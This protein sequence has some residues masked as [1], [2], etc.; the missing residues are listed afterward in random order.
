MKNLLT[1]LVVT[2]IIISASSCKKT[3]SSNGT[4]SQWNYNGT[5]YQ[6]STTTFATSSST[7]IIEAN[8]V[9]DTVTNFV[10]VSFGSKPVNNEKFSV[11]GQGGSIDSTSCGIIAGS[12]DSTQ[13]PN[14]LAQSAG[15]TTDSV[16]VT[17][18]NGKYHV[19]FA[20]VTMLEYKSLFTGI[21][22]TLIQQ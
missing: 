9:K 20:N 14:L 22:G 3:S 18:V 17:I 1:I 19:S 11:I 7:N 12:I 5:N 8:D 21:S 4:I 16:T 2:A 13:V 15:S 10:L 6:G